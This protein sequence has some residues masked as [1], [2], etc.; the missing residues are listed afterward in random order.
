[1]KNLDERLGGLV[2]KLDTAAGMLIVAS[3]T[4][5]TVKKAHKIVLDVSIALDEIINEILIEEDPEEK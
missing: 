4:D 1:V 3:M 5:P 2:S